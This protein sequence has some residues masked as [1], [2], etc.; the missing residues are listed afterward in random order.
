MSVGEAWKGEG[1]ENGFR[2][3][4]EEREVGVNE[5]VRGGLWR[6]W[7]EGSIRGRYKGQIEGEVRRSEE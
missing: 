7:Q 2:P 4:R 1:G 6:R 3:F 5:W